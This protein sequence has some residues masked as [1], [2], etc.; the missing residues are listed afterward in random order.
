MAQGRPMSEGLRMG[1]PSYGDEA[2]SLFHRKAFWATPTMRS[3]G[4]SQASPTQRAI[5]TPCHGDVAELMECVRRGVLL[6]GGLSM[7]SPTI[8]IHESFAHATS[9]FLR[10]PLEIVGITWRYDS[11]KPG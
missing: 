11:S 3:T 2:F 10:N 1:L 5:T 6:A 7:A 9:M 4:P 8:S